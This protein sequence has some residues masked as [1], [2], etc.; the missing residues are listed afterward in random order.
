[1][2]AHSLIINGLLAGSWR[3][4]MRGES[5]FVEAVV[6]RPLTPT[7]RRAFEAAAARLGKFMNVSVELVSK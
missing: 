1:V 2:F 7:G 4:T 5:L 6:Y 3:R